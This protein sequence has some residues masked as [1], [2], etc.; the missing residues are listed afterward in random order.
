M[1]EGMKGVKKEEGKGE[2]E[3]KGRKEREI[4]GGGT[5]GERGT[6]ERRVGSKRTVVVPGCGVGVGVCMCRGP[7]H[8]GTTVQ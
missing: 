1:L 7:L 4:D 3:G 5:E 6:W 8:R 2:G